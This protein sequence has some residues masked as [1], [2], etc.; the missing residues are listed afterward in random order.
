MNGNAY[1]HK[2]LEEYWIDRDKAC[3]NLLKGISL[4]AKDLSMKIVKEREK[5]ESFLDELFTSQKTLVD[6]CKDSSD[7]K[8]EKNK[9]NYEIENLGKDLSK[10]FKKYFYIIPILA[11]VIIFTVMKYRSND[12]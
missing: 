11:L 9:Q 6:A 3:S 12:E 5:K 8:I 4:G 7:E 1:F 10:L 2:G